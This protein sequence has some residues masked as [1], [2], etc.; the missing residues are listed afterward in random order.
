MTTFGSRQ[1]ML[2]WSGRERSMAGKV[3]P[4]A[5]LF[6]HCYRPST[7]LPAD[8]V[9]KLSYPKFSSAIRNIVLALTRLKKRCF[10][11]NIPE[12]SSGRARK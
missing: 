10:R 8:A 7:A 5:A 4:F 2:K 6:G 12:N 1:Q 3:S 11:K 9:E